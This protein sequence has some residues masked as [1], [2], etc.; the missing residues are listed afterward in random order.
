MSGVGQKQITVELLALL[1]LIPGHPRLITRVML[2]TAK[3]RVVTSGGVLSVS[4]VNMLCRT[5]QLL[6]SNNKTMLKVAKV[7]YF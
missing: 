5:F 2:I 6:S 7:S 1:L 4:R 3:L